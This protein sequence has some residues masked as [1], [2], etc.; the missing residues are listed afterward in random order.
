MSPANVDNVFRSLMS[1]IRQTFASA[2]QS[3]FAGTAALPIANGGTAATSAS[4]ALTS[5][6]ALD[7]TYRDMPVID[8]SASFN[9]ANSERGSGYNY[10]G[11]AGTVTLQ[12][13]TTEAINRG[14]FWVVRNGGT[15]A[16]TI[17]RGSG[18]NLYAN[19]SNS[20]ADA[21]IAIGGE[22]VIKCWGTDFYTVSGSGIS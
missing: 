16:L 6:G 10:T 12:P 18:V 1:L 7:A 13:N 2:L 19:G 5:L 8:K 3:F 17:T 9:T 11:P 15:G 22:A 4:A 14:A 21:V 20:S